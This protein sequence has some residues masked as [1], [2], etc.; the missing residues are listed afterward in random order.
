ME[1]EI[2]DKEL[3]RALAE[4]PIVQVGTIAEDHQFIEGDEYEAHYK[5]TK[6]TLLYTAIR[7]NLSVMPLI[8]TCL[9]N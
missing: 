4:L 8:M 2:E 6:E 5:I 1:T 3:I 7:I 9:P